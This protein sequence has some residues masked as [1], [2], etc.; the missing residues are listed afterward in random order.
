MLRRVKAE[1]LLGQ[2]ERTLRVQA[3]EVELPAV[4]GH[5]G[6]RE[7]VLRHLEAVLDRDV[8]RVARRASPRARGAPPG[9]RPTRG[10]RARG[11]SGARPARATRGTRARA[12]RGRRQASERVHDRLRRLLD[13]PVPPK[14]LAR[15]GATDLSR[16]SAPGVA[17]E[18]GE[19]G[20]DRA[21]SAR[22]TSSSSCSASSSAR[23][24]VVDAR[25]EAVGPCEPA[26]DR[27]SKRRIVLA[28]TQRFP[29][30]RHGV[31]G[32]RQLG[33]EHE[34]LGAPRACLRLGEQPARERPGVC[35]LAGGLVRARGCER[36]ASTLVAARLPASAAGRARRAR[37][38]RPARPALAPASDARSSTAG[39]GAVRRV[40]RERDVPSAQ[41]R[42][43]DDGRDPS[44]HAAPPVTEAQV[45][46]RREQGMREAHGAVLPLDHMRGRGRLER[47]EG[48]ARALQAATP[49]SS[50]SADASAS[51]S[52][53][54][55]REPGDAGVAAAP[56][57]SRE[58]GAAR[59]GRRRR[60]ARAPPRARRTGSLPTARGSGARS[61]VRTA[62]RAGHAERD[63][64]AP[65]LSGPTSQ[66][67]GTLRA[68]RALELGLVGA[69]TLRAP[70]REEH[71]HRCRAQP[72]QS[73]GEGARRWPVE[74][75]D[76]VDRHEERAGV[77]E[78]LQ[79]VAHRDRERTVVDGLGGHLAQQRH[80][81]R[82]PPRNAQRREHVV[83]HA[84]EQVAETRVRETTLRLR[85]SRREHHETMRARTFDT[86]LPERRL[87]DARR[88]PRGRA[89]P[90][91]R[92]ARRRTPRRRRAP[93][94]CRRPRTPSAS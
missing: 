53:V 59:A 24:G 9:A 89:R 91:R 90:A 7:M 60:R 13:E 51:A 30:Q 93:R 16:A 41:Q 39:H 40:P 27:R 44:M 34:R 56:R 65:T 70:S 62:G 71:E 57:A 2:L 3:G 75:L 35:P 18:P 5:H 87:A 36:P 4:D 22:S 45:E 73:E 79:R 94:P 11:R 42:V 61:A 28:V 83:D 63:A 19:D 25:P 47:V 33:E 48:D 69:G 12:A 15:S 76:V 74:P 88:R 17:A 52:R 86:R 21:G 82:P 64:A 67:A 1:L 80:L 85:G 10:P 54:A 78:Q 68:E 92:A 50:P 32:G 26:V 72:P 49:T 43:V 14:A 66:A 38:R 23:S 84:L 37:P 31:V 81:E 6:D 8:V 58:R 77:R 46:R 55:S 20:L 29:E